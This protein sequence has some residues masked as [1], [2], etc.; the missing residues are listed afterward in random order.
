M[1]YSIFDNDEIDLS[2]I[3]SAKLLKIETDSL[4]KITEDIKDMVG[5]ST[6][7]F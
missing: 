3:E 2:T 6:N 4:I 1:E 5:N 7:A